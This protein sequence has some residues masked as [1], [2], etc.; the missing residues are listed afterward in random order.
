[1]RKIISIALCLLTASCSLDE[2]PRDHIDEQEAYVTGDA[3]F[4]NTVSTLYNYI[5]GSAD[6]EGLQGTCRGIYDL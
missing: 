2:D 6:G 1:M 4:R 5:G 3:L